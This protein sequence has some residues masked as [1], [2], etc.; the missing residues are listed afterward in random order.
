MLNVNH[1][2]N[3]KRSVDLLEKKELKNYLPEI[4]KILKS[5]DIFGKTI[6]A[7]YKIEDKTINGITDL[8][9]ILDLCEEFGYDP[10]PYI[11]GERDPEVLKFLLLVDDA[12]EMISTL[13][14][15]E[16]AEQQEKNK[17]EEKG[18]LLFF[19]PNRLPHKH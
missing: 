19:D 8:K 9:L 13:P 1:K 11:T 7:L 12:E 10:Y 6:H 15:E 17:N 5:N 14:C 16:C 2:V 18:K 4:K 3:I